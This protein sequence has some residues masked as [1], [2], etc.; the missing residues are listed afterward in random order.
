MLKLLLTTLFAGMLSLGSLTT[1]VQEHS[2]KAKEEMVTA[3]TNEAFAEPF[4]EPHF[5]FHYFRSDGNYT[6]WDLWIW[7]QDEEGKG[8]TYTGED[9]YGKYVF[10]PISQFNDQTQINFIIRKSDWSSQ[11]SDLKIKYEDYE[12]QSDNA[13]HFY[14]LN[15]EETVYKTPE[16]VLLGRI[17]Y[18][19]FLNPTTV[20]VETNNPQA[21]YTIK[22]GATLVSTGTPNDKYVAA[23]YLYSADIVLPSEHIINLEEDY[24]I[25]IAFDDPLSPNKTNPISIAPLFDHELFVNSLT[26]DGNDLG[27]T[28]ADEKSI[29]KAW[30]PTTKSLKL[31]IYDNGTPTKVD[32]VL[33]N[34]EYSEYN[35]TRGEKG[36]WSVEV[37]G[38]L[39]GKYYTF[40]ATNSAGV[41]EFTDPYTR[42]AGVNGVRGM[43]VD[44]EKTNPEGWDEVDFSVKKPT[45]I[46]PYELHVADLTA[47]DTWNGQEKNRKKYL[48]L[49]EEGTTY[50]KNSVTVKTGFDHIKELGINALQIL[51][52]FD[53]AND[54]VNVSFNW[55][56]NPQNYNVLEGA[57]SSNPY[58]GLVRINEFKQV[59]KRYAEEDIRII[60]DV[61]YNH[62]ASLSAH[63]FSKLVPDYYF[64]YREN[65]SPSNA[66]GVGNDTAAERVMMARYMVDSTYF[67]ASEYKLGG[68]RFDLMGLHTVEAMN[69]LSNKLRNDYRDDI[70][71]FGEAWDMKDS[72]APVSKTLA[73]YQNVDQLNRVGAFNDQI[74][75]AIKGGVFKDSDRGFVQVPD[76]NIDL[77]MQRRIE[78][79][80]KGKIFNG[81]TSDPSKTVNYV[82][83]H[84]NNTLFDKLIL[85]GAGQFDTARLRQQ[86]LQAQS[87]VLTSQGISFLHAGSE[88]LRS[89]PLG[90]G[91][92]D[93]NSYQ[94]SYEVNSLKWDEKVDN[95]DIF[96]MYVQMV[97]LKRNNPAFQYDTRALVDE[98]V[99]VEFG[100]TF[101]YNNAVIRM[102]IQGDGVEYVVYF[103]GA[104]SRIRVDLDGYKVVVDTSGT[105][106]AGDFLTNN[107][108]VNA[109][110]TLIL[111]RST[112]NGGNTSEP[113]TSEPGGDNGTKL[114]GGAIAGIAIGSVGA[115]GGIASIVY[116]VLRRK[117][118]S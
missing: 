59:V 79:G 66:S 71:I 11:T 31:R 4:E 96:E 112:G 109:N 51:P 105:K 21:T 101:G 16:E 5:V 49:I 34:D 117:K 38:D 37:D 107:Y 62:V 43:I 25:E 26:Y 10:L 40:V 44:F 29:F 84:D 64:R 97:D 32:P 61:V 53:Q 75:D 63:S 87:F 72:Q 118:V 100:S 92:Y 13:Y 104:T 116:F 110:T 111:E 47:D 83:V 36:V 68:F 48:G 27:V 65:G 95:L 41:N 114:S 18:A 78:Y 85:A 19:A 57:Y 35:F 113:G 108:A 89:K 45:E 94:S 3:P 73:S 54:E 103:V 24:S 52:F 14:I 17:V 90:N 70:I 30:A 9:S 8:Y 46:I 115:V 91:K 15:L 80:L 23:R 42:A 102:T 7:G 74:R 56:Y 86:A 12:L 93:H 82:S 2:V 88:M 60:M 67:L 50:T 1:K 76:T 77:Q 98:N 6:G 106:T 39:H 69:M 22:Q 58:D 20:R 99:T 55:G 33:G 28:Y 81:G